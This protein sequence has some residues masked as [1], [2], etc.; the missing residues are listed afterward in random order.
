MADGPITLA[1]L[2][3]WPV[4]RLKGVGDR[5]A[6]ALASVGVENLADLLTYYPRRYVDRT[7]E[8]RIR[9]LVVGE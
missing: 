8:A 3:S 1:E 4:T 7:N 5:K 6:E 9:D 2:S